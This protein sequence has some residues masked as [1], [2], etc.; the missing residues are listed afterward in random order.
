MTPSGAWGLQ[1]GNTH[2]NSSDS[3]R[4]K[5]RTNRNRKHTQ[6]V[7]AEGK[8]DTDDPT[9]SPVKYLGRNK[10]MREG[11]VDT[12]DLS[13]HRRRSKPAKSK[14]GNTTPETNTSDEGYN[15]GV[16]YDRTRVPERDRRVDKHG[17][18]RR[19]RRDKKEYLPEDEEVEREDLSDGAA[20]AGGGGEPPEHPSE[21]SGDGGDGGS[22]PG[23]SDS[24]EHSDPDDSSE[25]YRRKANELQ[26][27]Y[28]EHKKRK[29]ERRRRQQARKQPVHRKHQSKKRDKNIPSTGM[30]KDN[31][32]PKTCTR[33][34]PRMKDRSR[35]TNTITPRKFSELPAHGYTIHMISRA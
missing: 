8:V 4:S 6:E 22:S 18:Q 32:T 21:G 17:S 23:G 33:L 30:R 29:K 25:E 24:A 12:N 34:R 11:E 13:Q 9:A 10:G 27:R 5:G 26:L 1:H 16:N 31:S 19:E 35:M 20:E 14:R 3:P 7:R 28:E 15:E 2:V